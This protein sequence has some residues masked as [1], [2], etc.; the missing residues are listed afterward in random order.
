RRPQ[1]SL[2][3]GAEHAEQDGQ[4]TAGDASLSASVSAEQALY[5]GGR[6]AASVDSARA[7]LESAQANYDS[8]NAE[9]TYSLRSAFVNLL[10][11]QEQVA[12]L[13]LIEQRRRDNLELVG[14]R[15]EGGREHKGSLALIEASFYEAQTEL[16]QAER[17]VDSA[18]RVLARTMGLAEDGPASTVAGSLE[19]GA[20]PE[21]MDWTAAAEQTPA[22]AGAQAAIRSA[23][24]SVRSARSGYRPD[25]SLAS[26]AGRSGN[27]DAFDTDR[28]SVGVRLSFPFWSGGQTRQEVAQARAQLARAEAQEAE[29]L[30]GLVS[31]LSESLLSFRNATENVRVQARYFEA[32]DLR[33]EIA[34]EQYGAGLLTFENWDV[35]ENERIS[36]QRRLLESQRAALLAEA[37]WRRATGRGAFVLEE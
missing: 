36:Y 11:A 3:G 13:R 15:Y 28:W 5:T 22:Y 12:V 30:N 33:A 14:L 8:A 16:R 31:D 21:S 1:L 27:E 10:H 20:A 26:S 32:A 35:I 29:T 2:G 18:R 23:E 6:L 37:A 34:R 19:S 24:A 9:V 4:G 17:Q 7:A 25:I